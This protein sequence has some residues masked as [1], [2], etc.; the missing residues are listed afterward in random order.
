MILIALMWA[1]ILSPWSKTG[2]PPTTLKDKS[3]A[4][5]AEPLCAA[6][7]TKIDALPKAYTAE[8]PEDRAAVLAKADAMVA[9]LVKQLHGLQP[10]VAEDRRVHR[11]V[12]R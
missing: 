2:D 5:T 9:T 4:A 8:S 3:Y 10:K 1:Y 11:P 12:A 7:Q 6:T